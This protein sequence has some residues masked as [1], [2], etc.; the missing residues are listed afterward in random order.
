[1]ILLDIIAVIPQK[2]YYIDGDP[3]DPNGV[4]YCADCLD[5]LPHVPEKSIDLVL[6]DPPYPDQHPEFGNTSI[7]IFDKL[8]CR[9]FIFWSAKVDFPLNYTAIHIWDKMMGVASQYERIFER[10]GQINYRLYRHCPIQ[11]EVHAQMKNDVFT[12]HPSQKPIKLILQ[13]LSEDKSD[14]V[15]DPFLGSGTTAVACKQ[16]S[17]KFIGIEISEKYCAIAKQRLQG[18]PESLFK[19]GGVK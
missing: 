9:Q 10:N 12:G 4:I 8:D 16:L 19:K 11:N 5:I 3:V 14:L 6:T 2:P 13:L 17:R 18:T 15:L 7:V 1:M